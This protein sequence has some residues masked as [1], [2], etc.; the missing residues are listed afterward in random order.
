MPEKPSNPLTIVALEVEGLK[1]IKAVRIKPNG[2]L[3]QITGKNRQGKTSILDGIWWALTGKSS[4]EQTNPINDN[5]EEARVLLD[6]GEVIITRRFR[7]KKGSDEEITQDLTVTT[8]KGVKFDKPQTLIDSML[9]ALTLDPLEFQRSDKR[10]QFDL[11]KGLVPGVDFDAIAKADKVDRE[12]REAIGRDMRRAQQAAAAISIPETM[13]EKPVDE[14]SLADDLETALA[15]NV[16]IVTRQNRR[17][18]AVKQ[19]EENET[20]ISLLAEELETLTARTAELKDALAKAAP[21]PDAIDIE[22]LRSRHAEARAANKA[23]DDVT[24]KQ[25]Y[26][27]EADDLEEQ[28]NALTA[29]IEKREK[30]KQTK[31]AAA[32]LPVEGL[33]VGDGEILLNGQPFDQGSDAEQLQASIALAMAANPQI[34]VIRIRDGS[35]LDSDARDWL[36]DL[37]ERKG[38]QVWMERVAEGA[39]VGFVIEDG[40]VKEIVE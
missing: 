1:R 35:L 29:D 21:L 7:K 18:N 40:Q 4:R 38:Y 10:K 24:R 9:G 14:E 5:A 20:R 12:K 22:L 34:R 36:E 15:H 28:Y 25:T 27:D 2:S 30:D 33:Q 31:I 23:F 26:R 16:E 32:K 6:M 37:I 19:I 11:V 3:V 13:P 8:A 17:S 39:P